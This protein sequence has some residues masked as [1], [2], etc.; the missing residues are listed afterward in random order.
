MYKHVCA[1][2]Q[3]D[4]ASASIMTTILGC[5]D[6]WAQGEMQ[7][8]CWETLQSYLLP[9]LHARRRPSLITSL[10]PLSYLSS[11][12]LFYTPYSPPNLHHRLTVLLCFIL[13][14]HPQETGSSFDVFIFRRLRGASAS[15]LVTAR[16]AVCMLAKR[17]GFCKQLQVKVCITLKLR[18]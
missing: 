9:C 11:P 10:F 16:S 2:P 8:S 13:L 6:W 18:H 7:R 1:M 4:E 3:S 12:S 15:L 17:M 5:A 14:F